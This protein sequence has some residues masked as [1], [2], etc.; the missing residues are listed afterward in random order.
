MTDFDAVI[1]G[2]GVVGLACGYALSTQGLNIAVLE[3]EK[4]IGSVTSSRNSE[5][6]HAG[7][8]YPK[9]SLKHLLCWRGRHLLYQFA[10]QTDIAH[11]KCGKLI[12]ATHPQELDKIEALYNQA[13]E[14]GIEN[15]HLLTP[16]QINTLEPNIYSVGGLFSGETG[17]IDA[18]GLCQALALAIEDRQGIIALNTPFLQATVRPYGFDIDIGGQEPTSLTSRFLIN[19]A[20][21]VA[22]Q[23]ARRIEGL[24]HQFCPK[25]FYARGC[26]FSLG[27]KP[28]FSHLVYPAPVEGG[29][30]IHATLDLSG[31]VRFGPDVEWL[32]MEDKNNPVFDYHVNAARGQDFYTAI[33]RYWP[34]L[35][36]GSLSTDYAGIRPK[37]SG[38]GQPATDFALE[39]VTLHGVV[40]LVNLFGIESPGLT[41]S[42]AIGEEV[43][44]RLNHS[45]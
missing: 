14:N 10:H 11:K 45:S 26:Y 32:E 22:A 35:P 20:G 5:V 39:D 13:Q 23:V 41:A 27:G 1:I 21:L 28:P 17:I 7:L 30:G 24:D 40:G 3:E 29:L 8:Y 44:R 31:R 42:L 38:R 36:Q 15:I 43:A 34:Q 33:R 6:I 19:S 16:A 37:L 12:V 18:H 9:N 25:F 4:M 2:A